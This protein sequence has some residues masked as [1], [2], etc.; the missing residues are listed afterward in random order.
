MKKTRKQGDKR[1]K[2]FFLNFGKLMLDGA[3]LSFA[4]LVLGTIIRGN[5]PLAVV[6]ESGIIAS[7]VGALVG[8]IVVAVCEE[9]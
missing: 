6:M 7:G 5:T 4:S 1:A 9:K 2:L 3:K 8:L